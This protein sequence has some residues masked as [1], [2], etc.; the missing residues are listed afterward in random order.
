ML[1]FNLRDEYWKKP[2]ELE[3]LKNKTIQAKAVL[4]IKE[5]PES[6]KFN[7][8]QGKAESDW[9]DSIPP[10]NWLFEY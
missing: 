9:I 1:K 5:S 10:H 4:E 7:I 2:A 8:F 3:S 6:K